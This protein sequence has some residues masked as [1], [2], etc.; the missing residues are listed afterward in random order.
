MGQN[1]EASS[2]IE[3]N[4]EQPLITPRTMYDY[5]NHT[6]IP[7]NDPEYQPVKEYLDPRAIFSERKFRDQP[8]GQKDPRYVTRRG[9]Y[10]DYHVKVVKELPASCTYNMKELFDQ[11]ANKKEAKKYPMDPK[12]MKYSYHDR[13]QMEEKNRKKPGVGTYNL[14]KTDKEIKEEN[15]E[16]KNRKKHIGDK[17]FF[18]EDTEFNSTEAP[19]MGSHNPHLQVPHRFRKDTTNH[20]YWI[21]KHDK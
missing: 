20:K 11:T 8:K 15:E 7:W 16:F 2:R 1:K 18:Y 17:R 5:D 9:F 12:L 3:N 4:P 10:M 14:N 19:G 13:I 21:K 6:N